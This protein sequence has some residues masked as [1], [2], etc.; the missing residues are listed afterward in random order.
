M[1]IEFCDIC[2]EPTGRSG[3]G[4][5]S[6]SN[7]EDQRAADEDENLCTCLNRFSFKESL[8]STGGPYENKNWRNG[9]KSLDDF[10]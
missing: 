3:K 9:R 1:D 2:G 4:E 5:D 6:G 7:R 8:K 10:G